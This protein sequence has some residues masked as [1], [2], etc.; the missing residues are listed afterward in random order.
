MSRLMNMVNNGHCSICID[1]FMWRKRLDCGI[2]TEN[3]SVEL[4]YIFIYI[5]PFSLKLAVGHPE[6]F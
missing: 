3:E 4:A 5:G 6:E 1:L 2:D